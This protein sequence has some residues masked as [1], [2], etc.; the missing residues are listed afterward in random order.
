MPQGHSITEYVWHRFGPGMYVFALA[1][2]IFYM[3]FSSL[4]S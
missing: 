4:R 2:V 1:V 3:L